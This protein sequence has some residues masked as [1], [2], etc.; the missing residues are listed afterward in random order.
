MAKI[1]TRA[2]FATLRN[3]F[4][5]ELNNRPAQMARDRIASVPATRALI[6]GT[7]STIRAHENAALEEMRRDYKELCR[8]SALAAPTQSDFDTA[9]EICRRHGVSA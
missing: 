1:T 4:F 5:E 7:V 6:D 8:I 2:D 9:E 3:A